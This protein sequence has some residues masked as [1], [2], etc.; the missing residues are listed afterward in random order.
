MPAFPAALQAHLR[1][2]RTVLQRSRPHARPARVG[3]HRRSLPRR[4]ARR[5]WTVTP[6]GA[7]LGATAMHPAATTGHH[8]SLPAVAHQRSTGGCGRGPSPAGNPTANIEGRNREAH[9][10]AGTSI[11]G[12]P[13]PGSYTDVPRIRCVF[14]PSIKGRAHTGA[15]LQDRGAT[16]RAMP[17]MD[18][19]LDDLGISEKRAFT[20][21][22]ALAANYGVLQSAVKSATQD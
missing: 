6:V 14:P 18:V 22:G 4:P 15:L 21:V 17:A 12:T 7:P 10:L 5:C 1:M 11:D 13:R 3:R 16:A 19:V 20:V 2:V 9:R 8:P